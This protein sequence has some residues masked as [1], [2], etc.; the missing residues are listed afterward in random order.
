MPSGD[1]EL[2]RVTAS[3]P[4]QWGDQFR[5]H[6]DWLCALPLWYTRSLACSDALNSHVLEICLN[7]EATCMS[8]HTRTDGPR[9]VE[10]YEY[11]AGE[12]VFIVFR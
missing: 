9:N 3:D 11:P 1:V 2:F 4:G 6:A 5:D 10:I 12:C 7:Y 8:I